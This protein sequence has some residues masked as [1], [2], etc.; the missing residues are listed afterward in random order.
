MLSVTVVLICVAMSW[1][2]ASKRV[3]FVFIQ[4]FRLIAVTPNR[5]FQL[6]IKSSFLVNVFCFVSF[7]LWYCVNSLF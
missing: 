3:T 1:C 5:N 2:L 6:V 4:V 7:I